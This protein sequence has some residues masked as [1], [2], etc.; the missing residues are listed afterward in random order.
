[1]SPRSS[2]SERPRSVLRL[3]ALQRIAHA[4]VQEAHFL[5]AKARLVDLEIGA[6]QHSGWNLLDGELQR[7]GR[8]I[9]ALVGDAAAA[10]LDAARIKFGRSV[11]V[12]SIQVPYLLLRLV[13]HAIKGLCFVRHRLLLN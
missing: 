3:R 2:E 4:V 5:N 9:E 13:A 11:V 6:K 8:G 10:L 1:M 12:E 7:F